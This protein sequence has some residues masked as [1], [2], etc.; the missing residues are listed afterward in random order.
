MVNKYMKKT[1]YDQ[2]NANQNHSKTLLHAHTGTSV[3]KKADNKK[4]WGECAET[5]TLMY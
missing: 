3:I 2:G 4:Y 5:G 1:I